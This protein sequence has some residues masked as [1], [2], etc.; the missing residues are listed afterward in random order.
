MPEDWKKTSVLCCKYACGVSRLDAKSNKDVYESLGMDVTAKGGDCSVVEWVKCG[1]LRW[2]G[3]VIRKNE[4][5]F[6]RSVLGHD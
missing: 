1:I 2:F 3:H 6:V 5:D 4:D